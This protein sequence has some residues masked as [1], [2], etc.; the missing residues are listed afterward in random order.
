MI[1]VFLLDDHELVR[2]GIAGLLQ[3]ERDLEVVGEAGS[4]REALVRIPAARPDVAVLDS[5]LPDGSGV[6]VCRE[7]ASTTPDV[8]C[9]VLTGYADEGALSAAVLA[10]AAG[11]LVKET[12]GLQLAAAIRRVAAGGSLLDPASTGQLLSHLQPRPVPDARLASLSHRE[13]QVLGLIADGMTNRQIGADLS[14]SEKTVKNYVSSLFVKLGMHR[15][16][17][18]AV[19][20]AEHRPVL[21]DV[22]ALPT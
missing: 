5:H 13:S 16:T 9:I 18:A 15:R 14:L 17:Q 1:R 4:V 8:R 10:G 19:F 7:L 6:E 20:G 22:R 2:R 11:Y 12:R 21:V 3:D